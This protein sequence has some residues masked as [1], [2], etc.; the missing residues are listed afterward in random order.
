[1]ANL[2][3]QSALVDN[4]NNLLRFSGLHGYSAKRHSFRFYKG[5]KNEHYELIRLL[6]ERAVHVSEW[7]Q[8]E[9]PQC[10]TDQ[11]HLDFGTPERVYWHFGYLSALND[12]SEL[13]QQ[14]GPA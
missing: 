8:K 3:F 9:S 13:L 12:I 7:L 10:F 4:L 11:R 5:M 14:T 1:M 2:R 6:R